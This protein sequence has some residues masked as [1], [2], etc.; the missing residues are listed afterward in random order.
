MVRL[1]S[2]KYYVPQGLKADLV[3]RFAAAQAKEA[4]QAAEPTADAELEPAFD[5]EEPQQAANGEA[6]EEVPVD[7]QETQL[8]E[9]ASLEAEEQQEAAETETRAQADQQEAAEEQDDQLDE[10]QPFDQEG[11][12]IEEPEAEGAAADIQDAMQEDTAGE[13]PQE[14]VTVSI[15]GRV[16]GL[17]WA[18]RQAITVLLLLLALWPAASNLTEHVIQM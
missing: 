12:A 9:G 6:H 18:L 1:P 3:K 7:L 16:L 10:A 13:E 8:A 17:L 14:M 2:T 5:T 4:E 15:A 11:Q